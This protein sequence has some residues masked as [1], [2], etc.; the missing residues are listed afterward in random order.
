MVFSINNPTLLKLS[1]QENKIYV[2]SGTTY[3]LS[4]NS[5]DVGGSGFSPF[6]FRVSLTRVLNIDWGTTCQVLKYVFHK[7]FPAVP[8]RITS[9]KSKVSE[10]GTSPCIMLITPFCST[11]NSFP[12]F[13]DRIPATVPICSCGHFISIPSIG[14]NNAE[15]AKSIDPNIDLLVAGINCANPR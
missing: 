5:S 7:A 12:R 3:S 14:S 13:P 8:P 2:L 6:L 15:S 10:A 1:H 9:D 11:F 4:T